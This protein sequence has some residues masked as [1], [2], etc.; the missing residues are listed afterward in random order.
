M[1]LMRN[2]ASSVV[3]KI[4]F[5]WKTWKQPLPIANFISNP[6]RRGCLLNRGGTYK[7]GDAIRERECLLERGDAY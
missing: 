6:A 2:V 5:E 7:R 1:M 3:Q 4:F